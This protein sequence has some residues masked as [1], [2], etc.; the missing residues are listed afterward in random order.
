MT[1]TDIDDQLVPIFSPPLAELLAHAEQIKGSPLS[2]S[3]VFDV[4]ANALGTMI[5]V[6]EAC[7]IDEER[8]YRDVH[9]ENCW[10]D[11]HRLR[12]QMVGAPLPK[13]ILCLPGDEGFVQRA[14]PILEAADIDYEVHDP[15]DLVEDAFRGANAGSIQEADF[16]RIAA[17]TALLYMVSRNYTSQEGPMAS[18]L[19]LRT[20]ARLLAEGAIAVKSECS[21]IAHSAQ[22]WHELAELSGAEWR[23]GPEFWRGLFNAYVQYPIGPNEAGDIFSGGM[24]LLGCP[25]VVIPVSLVERLPGGEESVVNTVADLFYTFCLYLLY[26]LRGSGWLSGDTFRPDLTW[27][28]IQVVWEPCTD[29][30]EDD[31]YFNP[32]GRWRFADLLE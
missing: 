26:E 23:E 25:D 9:H 18:H 12:A 32:F 21:G 20:G 10:A 4:R 5:S 29:W 22:R 7:D 2:E 17:H 19:F 31:E 13:I 14:A 3:E 8:G 16:K 15:S 11:W 6:E 27:P 1:E 24:H 28:R 30:E